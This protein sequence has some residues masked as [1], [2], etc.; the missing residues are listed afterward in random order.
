V[1]YVGALIALVVTFMLRRKLMSFPKGTDVM[2]K[3]QE[4]VSS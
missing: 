4:K 3:L 2:N 1:G